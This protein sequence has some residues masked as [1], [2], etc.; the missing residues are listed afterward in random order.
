MSYHITIMCKNLTLIKIDLFAVSRYVGLRGISNVKGGFGF[1]WSEFYGM[2]KLNLINWIIG[3]PGKSFSQVRSDVIWFVVIDYE[4][5][6]CW[7][8]IPY[9]GVGKISWWDF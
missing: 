4:N 6:G 7:Y 8:Q 2:R 1:L 3:F 5:A 9:K